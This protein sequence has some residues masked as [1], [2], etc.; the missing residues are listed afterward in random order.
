MTRHALIMADAIVFAIPACI[1]TTRGIKSYASIWPLGPHWWYLLITALILLGFIPMFTA[2]V[3]RYSLRIQNLDEERQPFTQ[4]F[5]M[6]GWILVIF[7]SCLGI[8]LKFFHIPTVFYAI[9]YPAL[10]T[11]LLVGAILF[12]V[13]ACKT[14]PREKN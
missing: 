2:I 7:M 6:R 11:S 5:P 8:V 1:I 13:M 10:G 14:S 3:R 4:M 9:F 12:A